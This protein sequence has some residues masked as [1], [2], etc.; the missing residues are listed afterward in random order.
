MKKEKQNIME[1]LKSKS[2]ET[3]TIWGNNY[4][5]EKLPQAL[6][7]AEAKIRET[8]VMFSQKEN[9]NMREQTRYILFQGIEI[10]KNIKENSIVKAMEES[11]IDEQT[12]KKIIAKSDKYMIKR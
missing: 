12:I 4:I 6:D 8:L 1:S 7:W 11:G 5:E 2:E 9:K 10:G 3:V